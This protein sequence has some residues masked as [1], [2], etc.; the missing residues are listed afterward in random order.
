MLY[1]EV[2]QSPEITILLCR[3]D[4]LSQ[5][6]ASPGHFFLIAL[7]ITLDITID[8]RRNATETQ[9]GASPLVTRKYVI[10]TIPA[11]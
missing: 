4:F 8:E 1:K 11:P 5:N 2:F 3:H 10:M 9:I 6:Y 7:K